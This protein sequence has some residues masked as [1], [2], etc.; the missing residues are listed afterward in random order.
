MPTLAGKEISQNGLGLMRLIWQYG[1]TP[2]EQ[3]FK[4]LKTALAA[5]ANVWNGADFYGTPDNNSLHL[6]NR[7][8]TAYPEDAERVV[9]TVKSGLVSMK[10][11]TM[12]CSRA[13]LRKFVDNALRILDGKKKI[14]VFGLG[15]VDPNVP[16][17]ESVRALA[18]LREEGKIGGI[19]LSEVRADTIRRAASVTKIDM[20]EAEVSLWSREVFENGVA[21]ACAEN[22]I[23]LVAHTPLGA[24][25]LTGTIKSVDDLPETHHRTVPRFQP[26]S[27]AQNRLLVEAMEAVAVAKG[28]SVAQLALSWLKAQGRKPGMPVIVPIPGARSEARVLENVQDVELTEDE[29]EEIEVILKKYPVAGARYPPAAARLNEY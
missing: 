27:I 10:T 3:A 16:V 28:C 21:E 19:Q 9:F 4:I 22:G 23:V 13:G 12:D 26:D 18:E 20:V 24:G 6:M 2:D 11:F 8:F 7:Y 25:M 14:D 1:P 15:R 29:L 17:E 5:G